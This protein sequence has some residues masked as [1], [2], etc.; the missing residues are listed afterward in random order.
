MEQNCFQFDEHYYTQ[1]DGL[2]LYTP[3]SAIL[4]GTCLKCM[5][6]IKIYLI[7]IK[8][9]ITG[10]FQHVDILVIYN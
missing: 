5:E 2:A 10:Y 6:E 3:T 7:L 1:T 4:A 8:H 9:H